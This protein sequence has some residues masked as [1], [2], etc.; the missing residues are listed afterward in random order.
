[1]ANPFAAETELLVL[2]LLSSEPSGLY[3]L[4]M[5]KKSACKLKRGSV[6]V[7]LGRLEERGYIKSRVPRDADHPGLPRPRY[8]LTA[9]GQKVLEAAELI[10]WQFARA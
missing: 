5:V 3:G 4:E 1:M 7:T 9:Q 10:G 8:T 6:Y 2:R